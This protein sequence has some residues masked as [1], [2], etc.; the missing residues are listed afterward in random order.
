M[1]D[2]T[3]VQLYQEKVKRQLVVLLCLSPL[4]QCMEFL[5]LLAPSGFAP[6]PSPFPIE[7]GVGSGFTACLGST[8]FLPLVQARRKEML[9]RDAA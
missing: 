9:T 7:T 6:P 5:Q 4:Y 3:S 1:D 8:P 2:E